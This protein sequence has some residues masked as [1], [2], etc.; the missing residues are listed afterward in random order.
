MSLLM[1]VLSSL[2]L[3]KYESDRPATCLI[4]GKLVVGNGK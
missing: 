4:F 1:K 3:D 2:E